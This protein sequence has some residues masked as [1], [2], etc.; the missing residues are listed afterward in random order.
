MRS[1]PKVDGYCVVSL[2][3]LFRPG[4]NTG[5]LR[6]DTRDVGVLKM[7]SSAISTIIPKQRTLSESHAGQEGIGGR[8]REWQEGIGDEKRMGGRCYAYLRKIQTAPPMD[9]RRAQT[10]PGG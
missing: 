2:R 1:S 9:R 10:A 8:D 7:L 5:P 6:I 3:H 4:E